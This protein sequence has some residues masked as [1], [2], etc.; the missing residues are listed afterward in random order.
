VT[1]TNRTFPDHGAVVRVAW[2]RES[3]ETTEIIAE[4]AP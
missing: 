2:P 4:S 1:F 3:F